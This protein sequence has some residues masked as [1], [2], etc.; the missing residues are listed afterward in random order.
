MG[1]TVLVETIG[2]DVEGEEQGS[3]CLNVV[4]I[5]EKFIQMDIEIEALKEALKKEKKRSRN[6][7]SKIKGK[8]EED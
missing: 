7:R 6:F 8:S 5:T 4:E 2:V 3:N 1:V